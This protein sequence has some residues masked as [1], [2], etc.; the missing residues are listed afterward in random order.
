ML[1]VM[2]GMHDNDK[3]GEV[4]PYRPE[5]KKQLSGQIGEVCL[6]ERGRRR[7]GENLKIYK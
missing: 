3:M 1:I 5:V 7:E 2:V 4:Y 6:A